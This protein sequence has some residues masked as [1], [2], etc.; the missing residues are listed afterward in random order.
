M[1]HAADRE[2]ARAFD[3]I[4][5]GYDQRYKGNAV[6]DYMRSAALAELDRLAQPR[7][8][9]LEVGCGTGRDAFHLAERG[10]HV[11]ATDVSPGMIRQLTARM[12]E[13]RT[14][15]WLLPQII[16]TAG[17][18]RLGL[19]W[20]GRFA[21]AY[22]F[23]GAL[24]C[25]PDLPAVARHLANLIQPGGRLV[26]TILNRWYPVEMAYFLARLRPLLALRRIWPG[27]A[28]ILVG[29]AYLRA[30]PHGIRR[31][32]SLLAPHFT[33]ES[34]RGLSIVTPP[35]HAEEVV[36]RLPTAWMNRLTTW[37]EQLGRLP[38]TRGLGDYFL[39]TARRAA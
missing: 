20:N 19:H 29:P 25:D 13:E 38:L 33:V 15:G 3:A 39:V 37:D 28:R 6:L 22:S 18:G 17:L 26:A 36:R 35:F 14:P 7:D 23:F 4:A 31:F 30:F 5:E 21:G 24:N 16:G 11:V 2:L 12:A 8:W 9:W 32:S 27:G 34:C 10:V 1:P